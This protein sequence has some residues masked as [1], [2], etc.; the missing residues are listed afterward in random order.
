MPPVKYWEIIAAKL[1]AA[2]WSWGYCSAIARDGWRWT[3]DAYR[4]DFLEVEERVC[5]V[6][7]SAV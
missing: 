7:P 1:S 6:L 3:V 4:Q 5:T 2:R